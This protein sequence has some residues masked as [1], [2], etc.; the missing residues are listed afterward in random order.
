MRFCFLVLPLVDVY[1][2]FQKFKTVHALMFAFWNTVLLVGIHLG[3]GVGVLLAQQVYFLSVYHRHRLLTLKER[4]SKALKF[5]LLHK[6]Q[7]NTFVHNLLGKH[8]V[9]LTT[10][11]VVYLHQNEQFKYMPAVSYYTMSAIHL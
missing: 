5:Y 9:E 2:N 8:F 6:A 1:L 10:L 7:P 3:V 11:S 4:L